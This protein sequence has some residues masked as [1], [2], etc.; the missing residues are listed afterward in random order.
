M[1]LRGSSVGIAFL[2]A[3]TVVAAPAADDKPLS[4]G[5]LR[6]SGTV[7]LQVTC[8][9][10]LQ[11]DFQIAVALLHSFF[12]EE[13][14]RRFEDIAKRDPECAMAWWGVAMTWYHPLWTPPTP[15][16]MSAGVA[17]VEKA[18]ALG[19]KSELEQGLIEA[20]DAY[21]RTEDQP[22]DPKDFAAMSCHGPRAHGARASA[23]RAAFEKLHGSFPENLEVTTFYALSL[24]G[25]AAPTDT[26]HTSHVAAGALLEPLFE[27]YPDHPGIPHYIIHAY[28]F[29]LL[30]ARGLVAARQYDDIAPWVPHAL[31]MPTHIYTRT[32]MWPES[33]EGNL[34]SAAASRDYGARYHG[35]ATYYEELHAL[36]YLEF[37]YLQT[38]QDEK[39]RGVVERIRA[40]EEIVPGSD[41]VA[42]YAL[43]AIPARYLLERRR[44]RDAAH[45][46]VIR[47]DFVD[48]FPFARAHVEFTRAVGAA[49]SGDVE[50]ARQAVSHLDALGKG[51]TEAKFQ[52]WIGQIEI[53]RL[54]ATA[55]LRRAEG[56]SEEAVDLLRQAAALEDKS[57]T[58]P[59]T[60]GQILPA[61]EQ[62]ADLLLELER[63]SEALVEYEKS[64]AAFPN[65]FN[66]HYGAARAAELAGKA[67]ISQEHYRQLVA[68]AGEGDGR[69]ETLDHARAYLAKR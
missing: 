31:H 5:D 47:P 45:V 41:L 68:M 29:P 16:D 51:M 35:G 28:D 26:A 21:F 62:L 17:A 59:V 60:P 7:H 32:G 50:A 14:R 69:R 2:L 24:M 19:G 38:A 64:L 42:A 36:D 25:S 22:A 63:P 52:W 1:S 18:K 48:R 40:V 9:P 67:D 3:L 43:G 15:E 23:F 30:A 56:K 13:A 53:Q 33:I 61:R 12:Y 66:S 34:A 4:V 8:D 20:I 27:K 54:A 39:A 10:E 55:W 57:G 49:R 46:E 37:A 6:K 65:R 44:W 11:E 58:H